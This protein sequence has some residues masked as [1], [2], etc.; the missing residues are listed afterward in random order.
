M[1]GQSHMDFS[2]KPQ[3]IAE[4]EKHHQ[5]AKIRITQI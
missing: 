3:T 2:K 5:A 1:S 4:N